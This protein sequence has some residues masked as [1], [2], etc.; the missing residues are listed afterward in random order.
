M[1]TY[2]FPLYPPPPPPELCKSG[3]VHC[4]SRGCV[5]LRLYCAGVIHGCPG[6]ARDVCFINGSSLVAKE[7]EDDGYITIEP[8]IEQPVKGGDLSL[9]TT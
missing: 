9:L 2:Y 3:E 1:F 6:V 4:G 8:S 5:P 7:K